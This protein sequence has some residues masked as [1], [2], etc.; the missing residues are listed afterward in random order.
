MGVLFT[1]QQL[2]ALHK[3]GM[4]DAEIARELGVCDSAVRY[5]RR[6]LGLKSAHAKAVM[7]PGFISDGV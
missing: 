7:R 5:H 1:E 4:N 2:I 3:K 6:K